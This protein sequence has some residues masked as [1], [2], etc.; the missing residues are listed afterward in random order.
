MSMHLDAPQAV[1]SGEELNLER[2][3]P[4]LK[5]HVPG[6]DGPLTVEQFGS[7][8]SNLTY[9]VRGPL[10]ELVLR[11]PPFGSKVQGAHD[12]DREFTVLAHLHDHYPPTPQPVLYCPDDSVIGAPFYVMDRILGVV[13]RAKPPADFSWSEDEVR[14]C[15][16]ACVDNLIKLHALDYRAV[17]LGELRKPGE[18]VRRQVDGWLR[19]YDGSQTDEIREVEDIAAWLRERIP[20]DTSAVIVHNDYKF[21]NIVFD[22]ENAS[23]IVGVLDWEMA[24]VGDPLADLGT[25]LS[26]WIEPG[27]AMELHGVQCFLT[28]H[29]GAFSREEVARYYAERSGRD[30][31]DILFYYVLGL[32]KLAVIVQQIYYRYAKGLTTDPRFAPMIHMVRLLARKAVQVIEAQTIAPV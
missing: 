19:R 12:M 16:M 13:L 18:Y 1:R 5:Q 7:G 15:C 24:T 32:L 10:R 29:P 9:L 2:L 23:N 28:L 11:R 6:L 14:N 25:S 3:I 22:P 27:D 31:S 26:Y 8:H 20:A 17:G 30:T 21:D 4:Y